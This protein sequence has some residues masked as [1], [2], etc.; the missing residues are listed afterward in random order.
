[1]R[2]N[3]YYVNES[4]V[5]PN[6]KVND[7]VYHGTN[8]DFDEFDKSER[9]VVQKGNTSKYGFWF[10]DSKDE[11]QQYAELSGRQNVKNAE[12]HERKIE[13]YLQRIEVAQRKQDWDTAEQLTMDMEE[14]E[15]DAM[16]SDDTGER[17]IQAYLNIE[18]PFVMEMKDKGFDWFVDHHEGAIE[19]VKEDGHDGIIF[20]DIYDSPQGLPDATTQYLVF[21]PKQIYIIKD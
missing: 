6:S 10:T 19:K 11:A 9:G 20:N 17:I 21:D 16:Y 3:E 1:M 2:F 14:L 4:K 12:D 15:A 18:N 8:Q 13:D 7:V 5:F